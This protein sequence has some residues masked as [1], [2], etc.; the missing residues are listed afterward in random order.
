[1][2]LS[3]GHR[4]ITE[5]TAREIEKELR[6]PN[7]WFDAPPGGAAKDLEPVPQP[8]VE[9]DKFIGAIERVLSQIEV[10]GR[11]VSAR[12]VAEAIM[13]VYQESLKGHSVDVASVLRLVSR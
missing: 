4:P 8:P 13:F 6:L 3:T 11:I 10:E 5:K 2:Q 7:L 1:M 9:V 12:L